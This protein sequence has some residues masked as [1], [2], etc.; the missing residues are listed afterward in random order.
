MV[1]HDAGNLGGGRQALG[2]VSF[3]LIE[4]PLSAAPNV[5]VAAAP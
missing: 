4:K 2:L 5:R 3:A 1:P